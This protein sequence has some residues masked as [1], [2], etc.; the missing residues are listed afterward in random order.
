LHGV[1]NHVGFWIDQE[2]E[3]SDVEI[4][5]PMYSC[6]VLLN[7]DERIAPSISAAKTG[8]TLVPGVSWE[9]NYY[10]EVSELEAWVQTPSGNYTAQRYPRPDST[11]PKVYVRVTNIA[12]PAP[13]L[14]VKSIQVTYEDESIGELVLKQP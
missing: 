14:R 4:G 3:N 13:E 2:N 11:S 12:P 6:A 8:L 10:H 9:T 5:E 7:T 1:V